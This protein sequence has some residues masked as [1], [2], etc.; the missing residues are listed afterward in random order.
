MTAKELFSN[1]KELNN[2]TDLIKDIIQGDPA[3]LSRLDSMNL[4]MTAIRKA[5]TYIM[6]SDGCTDQDRIQLLQESWRINYRAPVPTPEEFLTETYLGPTAKTIYPRIKNVFTTF[7]DPTSKYRNLILYP[8]ISWGKSFCSTL[9]TLY[10]SVCVSL[11]RD[12]YKYFGLSPATLLSQLLISYSLKKSRELLLAPYFNIME[13]SPFFEKV[14]RRDTMKE[15]KAEF[16]KR[17]YVDKLY[18]TTADPDSELVFDSG[19]TIKVT[20]SVQGL[21]GLSVITAVLSELAFFTDAGK[22]PEYIMRIYND[23]KSRIE[24]RMKGNRFGISIL[25]SSPNSLTNPIDDYIVNDAYKDSSNYIVKGSM[26]EWEPED[27]ENDFKT[28]NLFKVFTG[29]KGQPPRILEIDDPLLEDKS[30]DITK[31]IEVPGSMKQYFI[32]DLQKSLKDRAGIPTGAADNI[33][34]DYSIIEDM[35][36]NN[37]RNIYLNIYA[38]ANESPNQLIWHQV[39]DLFFKNKGG[40]YE[41][42]Y[43]PTIPRVVSVDQSYATDITSIAMAHIER[44]PDSESNVYVVDFT[45]AIVPT[46]D[47]INL[48]AIGSFIKDLKDIGKINI[49]EVS[50]DQFQSEVTLQNL[51]RDGFEV[52]K[53]SVDRTTGP[54]L[55]LISLMN[56][57]MVHVGKNIFLKNNL[58]CLHLV[59]SGKSSSMK[60]DHDASR[61]QVIVGD[62]SW[63]KS[64]IGYFGKDVSD[65]VAAAIELCTKNFVVPQVN[66]IGGPTREIGTIEFDKNLAKDKTNK[67][68]TKM[69]LSL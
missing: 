3:A 67:L 69:G 13:A 14:A 40:N 26:W 44:D 31:I 54:Y 8:H 21:L 18:Y 51:K 7:L 61:A 45:I 47:K 59:K 32:D 68:L 36:S 49:S 20:S 50:F 55:N 57:R 11:M 2:S 10:V 37:L 48:E 66:W 41:F 38:P 17:A 65:S 28:G 1:K 64:F 34:T 33:I 30:V 35:F 9:I 56:R 16:S 52:S 60:I 43:L 5:L 25:D 62:S 23:S 53:L 6:Q 24:S 58:K 22:S 27:Y 63:D 39:K 42:Y 29:G 46:Q 15:M 19:L 12:P 4:D